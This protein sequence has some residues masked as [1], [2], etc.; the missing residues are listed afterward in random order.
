MSR[1][2][3]GIHTMSDNIEG[4]KAGIAVADWI[5]ENALRPLK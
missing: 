4:Q 5:F 2:W 3:G 1:V